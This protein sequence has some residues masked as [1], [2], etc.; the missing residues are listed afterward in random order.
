[1]ALSAVDQEQCGGGT[2]LSRDDCCSLAIENAG[3]AGEFRPSLSI[4][5]S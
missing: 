5:I 3:R 1:M 2:H 4:A